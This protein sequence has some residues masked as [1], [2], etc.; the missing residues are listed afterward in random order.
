MEQLKPATMA[1]VAEDPAE[2]DTSS[3]GLADM[4]DDELFEIDLDAVNCIPPPHYWDSYL[5]ST[6]NALLANCLLPISEVSGAVPIASEDV[7]G[8]VP[9]ISQ[10]YNF[11]M[12]SD[13]MPLSELLRLP[14]MAAFGVPPRQMKA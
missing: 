13:P 1:F 5:T 4:E 8:V 7:S 14:F 10:S 3:K 2:H 12:M 6:G 11:V 9:M